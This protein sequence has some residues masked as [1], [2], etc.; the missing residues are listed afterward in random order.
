M[1]LCSVWL[2]VAECGLDK[3]IDSPF[4]A[5][6][7]GVGTLPTVDYGDVYSVTPEGRMAAMALLLLGI[8]LFGAIPATIT[9][10][11]WPTRLHRRRDRLQCTDS[12][13]R[14]THDGTH[15]RRLVPAATRFVPL[16]RIL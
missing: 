16:R 5:L 7:W 12:L 1:A 13:P 11:S 3:A 6:W 9:S 2:D 8:G 15:H 10:S 4:N 14:K